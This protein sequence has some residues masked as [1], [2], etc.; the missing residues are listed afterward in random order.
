MFNDFP[1]RQTTLPAYNYE[2][3]VEGNTI[4]KAYLSHSNIKR[5]GQGD[6]I[7]F[8]RSEDKQAIT[9][10]G[11]VEAIYIGIEDSGQILQLVGKRTV[12]SHEE[13]EEWAR[14]SPVSI[15]LFRHHFHLDRPV[16][17]KELIGA[18]LLKAAPES[19]KEITNEY[20]EIKKLGGIN[21][22]FTVH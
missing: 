9:S 21:E 18:H 14:K 17:L 16:G 13:I 11:V 20:A 5:M 4:K 22:R 6:L 8:Y 2:F 10:I 19:A 3:V 1:R 15:F 12:F 7:L